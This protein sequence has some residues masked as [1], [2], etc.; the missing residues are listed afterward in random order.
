MPQNEHIRTHHKLYGRST[1][2]DTIIK[3]KNNHRTHIVHGT[4]RKLIGLRG[5]KRAK[6]RRT[7][8]NDV[9]RNNSMGQKPTIHTKVNECV[10][11]NPLPVYL[12]EREQSTN[13][14]KPMNNQIE[15]TKNETLSRYD[16]RLSKARPIPESEMFKVQNS[17]K[18][19][20]KNWKRVITK[21]TFMHE[22][23]TNKPPKFERLLR[24]MGLRMTVANVTHPGLKTS[25]VLEIL[26]VRSNPNG[27]MFT[28]LGVITK[29]T[30]IEVDISNLGL[31]APLNKVICGKYAQ[32]TNNPENDGTIN[33]ILM[34]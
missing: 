24:P 2:F 13:Q 17:G 7:E 31:V 6:E 15:M 32:V 28:R 23:L 5:K 34:I 21:V 10:S 4:G 11:P 30:V 9:Q 18:R 19:G 33:A 27:H 16:A 12:L 1:K 14:V 3:K 20:K 29:G 22:T 8:A 25:H 26:T